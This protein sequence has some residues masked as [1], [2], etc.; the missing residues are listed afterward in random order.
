MR[1]ISECLEI[2][3]KHHQRI[4]NRAGIYEACNDSISKLEADY[5]IWQRDKDQDRKEKYS[6]GIL[7]L[8]ELIKGIRDL[9]K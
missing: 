6:S 5:E 7:P 3:V 9:A 4:S 2:S 1:Y 8:I